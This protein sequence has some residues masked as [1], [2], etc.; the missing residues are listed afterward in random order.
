MKPDQ[1]SRTA[2][3][4]A[5]IRACHRVYDRP[6]VFDDPFAVHLTDRTG[7]WA[8]RSRFL[9]WLIRRRLLRAF[10]PIEAQVLGRA[11]FAEDALEEALGRGLRQVVLVGAGLDS[12][13]LRR[14]DLESSVR[15]YELDHPASQRSKRAKLSRLGIDLPKN[16]EFVPIDFERERLSDALAASSFAGEEKTFFIWLGTTPYLTE[17]AIFSTLESIRAVACAGSEVVLDYGIAARLLGPEALV[18][19]AKLARRTR[20]SGEPL[21]PKDFDPETFPERV[22]GLGYELIENLS[23]DEQQE[24]YFRGRDDGLIPTPVSYFAHFRVSDVRG[25]TPTV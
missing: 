6:V 19:V 23:P 14:R 25:Q 20:R 16:L 8:C 17:K 21:V 5:A 10:R 1:S 4:A 11:R 24:R 7:R 22:C 2:E 13:A 15:V 3:G 18:T 12:F 9:H